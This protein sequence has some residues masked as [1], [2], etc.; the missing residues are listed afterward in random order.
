VTN[1]SALKGDGLMAME[2]GGEKVACD[3]AKASLATPAIHGGAAL[4]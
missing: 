3:M 2:L 1:R 4:R